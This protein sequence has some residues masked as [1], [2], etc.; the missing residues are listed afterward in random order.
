MT[1]TQFR[2]QL[3]ALGFSQMGFARY[4]ECDGRSVRRWCSGEQDIPRWVAVMLGLLDQVHGR[5]GSRAP[6]P[7]TAVAPFPSRPVAPPLED[8]P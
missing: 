1:P 4:V 7:R 8:A 6:S 3:A 2:R 5:A